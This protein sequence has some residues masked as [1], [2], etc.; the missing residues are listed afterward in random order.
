MAIINIAKY[1]NLPAGTYREIIDASQRPDTPFNQSR[2]LVGFSR[3]G[4]FNTPILVRNNNEAKLIFGDIDRFLEKRGSFFHRSLSHALE[5]GPVYALNLRKLNPSITPDLVD[6]QAVSASYG[7]DNETE[8]RIELKELYKTDKFWSVDPEKLQEVVNPSSDALIRMANV[9][10]G[11]LTIIMTKYDDTAFDIPASEWYTGNNK[12]EWMN[13]NDLISDFLV[14]VTVIRGDYGPTRYQELSTDAIFSEF[15]AYDALA[16]EESGLIKGKYADFINAQSVEVLKTFRGSLIPGFVDRN[17]ENYYIV[18]NIN[19][20]SSET[21]FILDLNE[22]AFDGTVAP[23]NLLASGDTLVTSADMLSYKV[24]TTSMSESLALYT[25]DI[26]G[27]PV[28]NTSTEFY[29]EYLGKPVAWTS[30]DSY[31]AGTIVENNSVFY[32]KSNIAVT[33]EVA[34]TEPG[35]GASFATSWSVYT[36]AISATPQIRVGDLVKAVTGD[37]LIRIS[38]VQL[39][40]PGSYVSKVITTSPV[41]QT[42]TA[43]LKF[44][45]VSSHATHL[46]PFSLE[47]F[48]WTADHLPDGTWQSIKERILSVLTD[49]NIGAALTDRES[50]DFRYLVDTFAGGIDANSKSAFT[51]ICSERQNMFGIINAPSMNAFRKSTNPSFLDVSGNLSTELIREG[52]KEGTGTFKFTLPAVNQGGFFG[53]FY[54]PHLIEREGAK[55]LVVPPA[56]LVSNLYMAKYRVANPWTIIAGRDW[57]LSGG[58]VVSVEFELNREDRLN[59]EKLGINPIVFARGSGL[60]IKGNLT[61]Q[62]KPKSALSSINGTE[63]VIYLQ[64]QIEAILS[65]YEF[66]VSDEPTRAKIKNLADSVCSQ[67]QA[68]GGIFDYQNIMDRSNNTDEVIDNEIG[69]LNTYIEIAKGMRILVNPITILRTGG[70]AAGGFA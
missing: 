7:I 5:A 67:V 17:G 63:V 51:K 39:A 53:A 9:G 1:N 50:T 20:A 22:D 15:F 26:D 62:Q 40:S 47:G 58:S 4:P 2:L 65:R 66:K 24:D 48:V 41:D 38:S 31:T 57:V 8:A 33:A 60:I 16:P 61:A 6:G 46:Q 34:G 45:T 14:E 18:G 42:G 49:T 64:D 55:E 27:L 43:V 59:F 36:G 12:P 13:D 44:K 69:V 28:T 70:I 10:Q 25:G 23:I 35:V 37:K 19:A 68:G 52:G 56:A 11:N 21:G 30:G 32:L 3:K 54:G 29:I